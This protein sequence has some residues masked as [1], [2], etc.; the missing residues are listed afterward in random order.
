MQ[1][2][3]PFKKNADKLTIDDNMI[4]NGG[5]CLYVT[6]RLR[7]KFLAFCMTKIIPAFRAQFN[8]LKSQHGGR[9]W[10]LTF[11]KW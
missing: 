2:K 1:A 9:E 8:A 5:T 6:P 11:R 3:E 4:F 7:D 10:M